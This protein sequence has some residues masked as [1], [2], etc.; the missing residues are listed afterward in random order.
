LNKC[1]K[2]ILTNINL[3]GG[4]IYIYDEVTGLSIMI[5]L[6]MVSVDLYIIYWF[7]KLANIIEDFMDYY[8]ANP[9]E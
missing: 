1:I 2:T 3:G 9:K 4:I 7:I 6:L 8:M 5:Y